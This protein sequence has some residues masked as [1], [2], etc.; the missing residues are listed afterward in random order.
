MA[1]TDELANP[2]A[3]FVA[4]Q[5]PDDE[6]SLVPVP[7]AQ[8]IAGLTNAASKA[9]RA[10]MSTGVN[11]HAP[12]LVGP[13]LP[14]AGVP[15]SMNFTA[16]P[17]CGLAGEGQHVEYCLDGYIA[18]VLVE[19]D[20]GVPVVPDPGLGVVQVTGL[21]ART[22]V[23]SDEGDVV[24]V[25]GSLARTDGHAAIVQVA[26][27]G[28]QFLALAAVAR[29]RAYQHV[30]SGVNRHGRVIFVED[31]PPLVRAVV[32]HANVVRVKGQHMSNG[33]AVR[34]LVLGNLNLGAR[35]A[36]RELGVDEDRIAGDVRRLRGEEERVLAG[37]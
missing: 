34:G 9:A 19:Y 8:L 26:G 4:I 3:A 7:S 33:D 37:P 28:G 36:A 13:R 1:R 12:A 6:G 27:R 11:S 5:K 22:G 25:T 32:P 31:R 23:L 18:L 10:S 16:P 14:A 2:R 20:L 21:A 30:E 15:V 35:L 29:R 17:Q 24:G